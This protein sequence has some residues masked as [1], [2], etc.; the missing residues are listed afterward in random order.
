MTL[1]A[2]R[3]VVCIALLLKFLFAGCYHCL[4]VVVF[5]FNLKL[6][7]FLKQ[8]CSTV[9]LVHFIVNFMSIS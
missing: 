1:L 8:P 7:D 5:F 2:T 9:Q 3:D 4:L 6:Y